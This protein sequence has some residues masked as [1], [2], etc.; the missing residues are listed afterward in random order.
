MKSC[1][2]SFLPI[3]IFTDQGKHIALVL[4][5]VLTLIMYGQQLQFYF[6]RSNFNVSNTSGSSN[7][8]DCPG[9]NIFIIHIV[10][11][12]NPWN[13]IPWSLE[14]F[15]RC[16]ARTIKRGSCYW[17]SIGFNKVVHV[18]HILCVSDCSPVLSAYIVNLY[19]IKNIDNL[20]AKF[21]NIFWVQRV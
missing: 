8:I 4:G 20:H 7:T 9:K 15:Q 2:K 17:K 18:V 5:F 10:L 6:V 19:N 13:R 11:T 12:V 14:P 21:A 16:L 1:R 3:Q